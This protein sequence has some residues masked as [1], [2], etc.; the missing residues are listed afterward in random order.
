MVVTQWFN[1]GKSVNG[2]KRLLLISP[3]VTKVLFVTLKL[4]LSNFLCMITWFKLVISEISL[5]KNCYIY[6]CALFCHFSGSICSK[7]CYYS[8]R[9]GLKEG[10]SWRQ[11]VS[12][13]FNLTNMV[14]LH[15]SKYWR[16]NT[17]GGLFMTKILQ[18]KF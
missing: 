5:C 9:Q 4:I 2:V 16:Q 1:L 11:G 7:K 17:G 8:K 13:N 3:F 6:T 14:C 10:E 18:W 15:L 12:S